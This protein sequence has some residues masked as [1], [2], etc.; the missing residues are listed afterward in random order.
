MATAVKGD[1]REHRVI[2]P[3]GARDARPRA[4]LRSSDEEFDPDFDAIAFTQ[5]YSKL[6]ATLSASQTVSTGHDSLLSLMLPGSYVEQNLNPADSAT[7]YLL[8]SLLNPTL[9]C[10]WIFRRGAARRPYRTCT[11]RS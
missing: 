2:R 3:G 6:A 9:A 11:S 1:P 5:L 8:S 4:V 7:Q 10:S